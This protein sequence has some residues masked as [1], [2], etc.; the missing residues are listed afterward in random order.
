MDRLKRYIITFGDIG[1]E[2]HNIFALN[3]PGDLLSAR[4][5]IDEGSR[6]LLVHAGSDA[7]YL[8]AAGWLKTR[9]GAAEVTDWYRKEDWSDYESVVCDAQLLDGFR[10]NE[11]FLRIPF[12]ERHADLSENPTDHFVLGYARSFP[13]R[14]WDEEAAIWILTEKEWDIRGLIRTF[15]AENLESGISGGE[16]VHSGPL[17]PEDFLENEAAGVLPEPDFTNIGITWENTFSRKKSREPE[18]ELEE[19]LEA[20]GTLE[21]ETYAALKNRISEYLQT[22][23]EEEV[24]R[25]GYLN[26]ARLIREKLIPEAEDRQ[27]RL[28]EKEQSVRHEERVLSDKLKNAGHHAASAPL[29]KGVRA[30]SAAEYAAAL[31]SVLSVRRRLTDIQ[32]IGRAMKFLVREAESLAEAL[33]EGG[34]T[35]DAYRGEAAKSRS[36]HTETAGKEG[37]MCFASCLPVEAE[38][39]G[40][41]VRKRLIRSREELR[42]L[43][44]ELYSRYGEALKD[45]LRGGA[46]TPDG[47]PVQAHGN[48]A[49]LPED[50]GMDMEDRNGVLRITAWYP[51]QYEGRYGSEYLTAHSMTGDERRREMLDRILAGFERGVLTADRDKNIRRGETVYE[52]IHDL[53]SLT[54]WMLTHPEEA[55]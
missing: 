54:D 3:E 44:E 15:I 40:R 38:E 13:G 14:L 51:I 18:R 36:R 53:P 32:R 30:C 19:H 33:E 21:E 22:L 43:E 39:A 49:L 52:G 23:A 45:R 42:G 4:L 2:G 12:G 25:T 37:S 16:N 8:A 9:Y 55:L 48:I 47:A 7:G 27:K 11:Q 35:V 34:K 50:G 20:Y 24:R 29:E 31:A 46:C 1:A 10:E 28:R 5:P 6:I 17:L 41:L 26:A